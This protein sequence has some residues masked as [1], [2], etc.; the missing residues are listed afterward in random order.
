MALLYKQLANQLASQIDRGVYLPGDRL[1]GVRVCSR[2]EQ[3]SP[4]TVV[5]AYEQ[6]ERD[7][8]IESRPRSG[9][10]VRPRLVASHDE[11][12][13]SKPASKPKA[14][15]GHQLVSQMLAQTGEPDMIQLGANIPSAGYMPTAAIGREIR[16]VTQ[17]HADRLA[18][19]ELPM[20]L[21][22]LRG[23]IAQY[24]AR[25]GCAVHADDILVTNGCQEA[26]YLGLK[27]LTQPG[28]VVAVESPTYFG[29]LQA[30]DSL[31]LKAIEIP[32][33]SRTGISIDAL[34]LALEQWP[35]KACVLV[36]NFAN[37]LGALM[38]GA[39]KQALIDLL[40]RHPHV[41]VIEDD[42]YGDLYFGARRPGTLKA[43]DKHGQVMYCS[44]YSKSLSAGLRIGW[45]IAP[46]HLEQ[47]KL[48]KFGVSCATSVIN[49]LVLAG[50][51]ETGGYERH[52]RSLRLTLAQN[53][54]RLSERV[55]RH[56][57]DNVRI[58]RPDGGLSI[59]IELPGAVDTT[60]LFN[61]ASSFGVNI[62][63]GQIFSTDPKKYR[64]CLRLNAG[65]LWNA[66]LEAGIV[67]L[68]QAV[69]ARAAATA[70]SQKT[71]SK[72]KSNRQ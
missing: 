32:T 12:G 45:M 59:W 24:M 11:P 23:L 51:L 13:F 21:P 44:S 66:D 18:D 62:A 67:R 16:K 4:S 43:H 9:F 36:P 3:V 42:I 61:Q 26:I 47:L 37:P 1:P 41:S 20:G 22:G 33:H 52:L 70:T 64:H 63:P 65:V 30:L 19:Y 55:L 25:I 39:H 71:P 6:L 49:Q 56:F 38:P 53:V 10:Y 57:P 5:A 7:G 31:G 14:V 68:G 17:R 35:V 40:H 46:R 50:L 72:Q 69:C 58:S 27:C 34:Q 8:Y 15:T 48:A 2:D 29:L 54:A 28:D 60:E